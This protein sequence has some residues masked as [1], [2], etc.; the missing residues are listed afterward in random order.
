MYTPLRL[1]EQI[2]TMV[3]VRQCPELSKQANADSRKFAE[4]FYAIDRA[5]KF[6]TLIVEWRKARGSS[7]NEWTDPIG[8]ITDY[9][10]QFEAATG[11]E[12]NNV[13]NFASQMLLHLL[14]IEWGKHKRVYK[15][16]P[17]M[18]DTFCTMSIAKGVPL[19]AIMNLPMKCFYIDFACNCP[20]SD[21]A[22][23]C[24]VTYDVLGTS[25]LW[26]ITCVADTERV[27]YINTDLFTKVDEEVTDS[28]T[29]T[30]D[31]DAFKKH[32][33]LQ[34]EDG[35]KITLN[36]QMLLQFF[37]NFCTY[38]YAANNDVEYTERTRQVYKPT[39]EGAE[40]KNKM[41]EI[42]E[43]GVGYKYSRS[44]SQSKVRVKYVGEK[45]P[46]VGK[47]PYSS[48]YRCAHWHHFWTNDPDIPG[49]KKLIVKWVE[50]TFV[51]GNKDSDKVVVQK[52][53]K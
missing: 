20:F 35:S 21:R 23:G 7:F 31:I 50:G 9:I 38:L 15:I 30:F 37:A 32:R 5:L 17:D 33:H 46:V 4:N 45:S 8:D 49:E 25:L 12:P 27:L 22:V 51:K 13:C 2:G 34:L 18:M 53:T 24:F 42:E 44:I 47:R 40:P 16:E 1:M 3:T 43:L 19:K 11:L 41:R 29:V 52:V 6:V 26:H 36:E 14:Q 10:Q 28:T 39:P 48:N